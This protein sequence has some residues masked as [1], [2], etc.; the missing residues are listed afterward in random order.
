MTTIEIWQPRYKDR[1]VLLAKYK[2]ETA[3][4]DI[5]VVFTKAKHLE[6]KAFHIS[7]ELAMQCPLDD[8]G[9]IGCYAVPFDLMTG[10][11]PSDTW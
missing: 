8:N 3:D 5:R 7:R 11:T 10:E 2:V 9:K 1:I 4:E 6:G